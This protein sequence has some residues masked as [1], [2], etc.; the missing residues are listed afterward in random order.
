VI[1]PRIRPGKA[2]DLVECDR[3][4]ADTTEG[5]QEQ[6]M[7]QAEPLTAEIARRLSSSVDDLG[8]RTRKGQA[9]QS[10]MQTAL[11]KPARRNWRPADAA[12]G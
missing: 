7:Q 4:T 9:R 2:A 8:A 1:A 11:Q 3:A 5:T 12:I 10:H 6:L